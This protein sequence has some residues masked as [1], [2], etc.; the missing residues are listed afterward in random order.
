[1]RMFYVRWEPDYGSM[2]TAFLPKNLHE[3]RS[4]PFGMRAVY[5][6]KTDF[7]FAEVWEMF[8][9][10][11]RPQEYYGAMSLVYWQFYR[12]LYEKLQEIAADGKATR[13]Y[14]R[15]ILK[16]YRKHLQK[17][18]AFVRYSDDALY[19]QNEVFRRTAALILMKYHL[20]IKFP[21]HGKLPF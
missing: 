9:R 14:R 16:F 17:W 20:K 7:T 12:E 5:A 21:A 6:R 1:M 2:H 4:V 8:L 11:G 10:I 19:P 15:P 13:K 18:V 3:I